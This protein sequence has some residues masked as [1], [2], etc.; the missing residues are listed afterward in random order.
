MNNI[1]KFDILKHDY[2]FCCT[3]VHGFRQKSISK[4]MGN[5]EVFVFYNFG[6]E[7]LSPAS[8]VNVS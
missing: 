5:Q 6:I 2:A 3:L 1:D 8:F 7:I 4:E